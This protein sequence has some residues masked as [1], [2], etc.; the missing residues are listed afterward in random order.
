MVL[1][2]KSKHVGVM[3]FEISFKHM[4]Y[5]I[6]VVSDSQVKKLKAICGSYSTYA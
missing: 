4:F 6:K 5:A 1:G 3:M 2:R